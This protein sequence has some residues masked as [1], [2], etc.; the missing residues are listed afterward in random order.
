MARS[1]ERPSSTGP[2]QQEWSPISGKGSGVREIPTV[3][4]VGGLEAV[5]HIVDKF[6]E[7]HGG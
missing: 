1:S 7:Y 5:L 6:P 3:R 2:R 4:A